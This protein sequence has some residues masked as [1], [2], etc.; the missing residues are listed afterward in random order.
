MVK[1]ERVHY[2]Q[3]CDYTGLG[4][5]GT[6]A[7]R[8][9][10]NRIAMQ[11]ASV[12]FRLTAAATYAAV[13]LF[14]AAARAADI[15]PPP[16][17][18]AETRSIDAGEPSPEPPAVSPP[19]LPE[20]LQPG[21]V[22]FEARRKKALETGKES[23]LDQYLKDGPGNPFAPRAREAV[24]DIRFRRCRDENTVKGYAAFIAKYPDS[25]HVAE[26]SLRTDELIFAP[27]SRGNSIESYSRFIDDF[28]EN[29]LI[30]AAKAAMEDLIFDEVKKADSIIAWAEFLRDHAATERAAE[31]LA[32]KDELEY[33]PY[34]KKD[35]EEGYREFLRGFP[36]NRNREE[37][38][39]RMMELRTVRVRRETDAICEEAKMEGSHSCDFVAF[40]E[41]TLRVKIVRLSGGEQGQQLLMGGPGYAEEALRR[42]SAWKS[43]T[44]KRL[45]RILGVI[46]VTVE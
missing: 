12:L 42:Y 27:F 19:P 29:R 35:A 22:I 23:I 45:L 32:L 13:F 36:V 20:P 4:T 37:A 44:I 3:A 10:A 11:P 14:C 28:P 26:A 40:E 31:A 2:N 24:D 38:R 5:A 43:E 6:Y 7:G 33:G 39:K 17:G 1:A 21:E 8:G 9:I 30:P 16:D 25:R 41:E 46:S 15:T 18:P 34:K